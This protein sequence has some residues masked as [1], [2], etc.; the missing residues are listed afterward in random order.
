MLFVIAR[1]VLFASRFPVWFASV[2]IAS[3]LMMF[4]GW[5]ISETRQER[6]MDFVAVVVELALWTLLFFV[7]LYLVNPDLYWE[8]IE[9]LPFGRFVCNVGARGI[10][11]AFRGFFYGLT[12]NADLFCI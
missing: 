3:V 8:F 1:G 10:G 6:V 12:G 5:A 4:V 11:A 7:L 9:R 2:I